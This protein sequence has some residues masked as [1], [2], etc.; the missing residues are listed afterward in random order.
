MF[1]AVGYLSFVIVTLNWF[2]CFKFGY[3]GRLTMI[4]IY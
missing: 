4:K 2:I 3:N 1:E